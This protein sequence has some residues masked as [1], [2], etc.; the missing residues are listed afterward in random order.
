VPKNL[1]N[2]KKPIEDIDVVKVFMACPKR[3]VFG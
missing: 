1:K 2:H 3:V